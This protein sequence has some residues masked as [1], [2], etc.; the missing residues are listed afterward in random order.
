[1]RTAPW[2]YP[3]VSFISLEATGF[4]PD[5]IA[6]NL[7]AVCTGQQESAWLAGVAMV[8]EGYTNLGIITC[9]D[10][11]PLNQWLWGY[12][13]G[14]NFAAKRDGIEGITVRNHYA[15]S[16]SPNPETQTL[17]A[18]WYADGIECIQCNAAGGNNSVIAAATA[19]NKPVFGADADLSKEGPTVVTSMVVDR[20]IVTQ[21][22]LTSIYDGT[23]DNNNGEEDWRG[24]AVGVSRLAPWENCRFENYTYDQY[25]EDIAALTNDTNQCRTGMI[26]P[27]DA[28]DIAALLALMGDGL[29]ITVNNIA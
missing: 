3:D 22:V 2:D 25:Q 14:V 27:D 4:L 17:A 13:Q 18:S 20:T 10:I 23:F 6:P 9:W 15:N 19:A 24:A 29:V 11:P 1:M 28:V 16:A 8:G 5:E 12:I 26:T 21:D 7:R